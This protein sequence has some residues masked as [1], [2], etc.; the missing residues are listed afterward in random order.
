[1]PWVAPPEP[2]PLHEVEHSPT[3]SVRHAR[4]HRSRWAVPRLRVLSYG[5]NTPNPAPRK[6]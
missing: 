3:H 2:Q 6:A 5:T 1:M 4:I